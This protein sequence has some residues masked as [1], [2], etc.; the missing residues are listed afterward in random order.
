MT[1]TDARNEADV[2]FIGTVE[3]IEPAKGD[4]LPEWTVTLR[5]QRPLKG[6]L[7]KTV[8]V[9]TSQREVNCG[10]PFVAGRQ[11]VVYARRR[12]ENT[13]RVD[14]CLRTR[15]LAWAAEDLRAFGVKSATRPD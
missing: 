14:A 2:V 9:M 10:Y 11:F 5:V 4:P 12:A 15:P 13:L 1:P 6:E 7:A 8:V 3:K